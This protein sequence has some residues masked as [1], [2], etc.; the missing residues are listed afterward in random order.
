MIW[1]GIDCGKHTGMAVWD[2]VERRFISIATLPL[3]AA[4]FAVRDLAQNNRDLT[5]VFEDARL[6]KWLPRERSLAEFKGRAMGGG[7][8]R[9]DATIWQEFLTAFGIS[10]IAQAPTRGLTK[11]NAESFAR[12][13]GYQQRTSEH[14]RDAAL[15]VYGRKS[16]TRR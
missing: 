7:S 11:W 14:A 9:R 3:H 4:L 16:T 10:F 15:L 13:T 6:R 1:V 5:V 12:V 8:V 2:D